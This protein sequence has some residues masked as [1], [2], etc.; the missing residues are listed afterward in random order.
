MI[1]DF[2][3]EKLVAPLQKWFIENARVLPWR[4]AKNAYYI[5]VSE[6]MLQQ[7][8][9]EAV[10]P[11]FARFIGELPDV[12]AL[13]DCDEDRLLKLWE[14][15]GYYNRARNLKIAATQVIEQYEGKIPEEYGELLKLKGIG[16]YTAGAIASISYEKAVP[17]VDGNVLRVLSRVAADDRD[18]M[19]QSVRK[20][21]EESLFALMNG[22]QYSDKKPA[23]KYDEL[24][25]SI[26]N[27]ALM[28][29]GATVCLPNGQPHCNACPWEE[30]CEA[31]KQGKI[32]DLPVKTKPKKRK[33]EKR[34]VLIIKDGDLLALK[35]RPNK[36]LLAGL[37]ELPNVEGYFTKKQ[38]QE[39][40]ENHGYLPVRIQS[41]DSAKHIFSHVEWHMKG[42]VVF[43]QANEYDEAEH[44]Q[45]QT[46]VNQEDWIFVEVEQTKEQYAIPSAFAKYTEY[47]N[48]VLGKDAI[49]TVK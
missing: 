25:P 20:S 3:L 22:V 4:E 40:V 1:D 29:L 15:L 34:T 39:Y 37:Y 38:V 23:N 10:K 33:I 13:A 49:E 42:Y 7:T 35:K 26:F 44:V 8:R 43:L 45:I 9:V 36:G 41:L 17:A 6:I 28:E 46:K 19:K 27:Q 2:G 47:L 48:M 11:Y 32:M 31:K 14:G 30:I 12:K 18:I 5:W 21:I 24:V 16:N